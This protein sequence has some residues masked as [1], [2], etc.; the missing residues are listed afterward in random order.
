MPEPTLDRWADLIEQ[1]A[2]S[3]GQTLSADVV[4]EL[5]CYVADLYAEAREDGASE[6]VAC[7]RVA[8]VLE[9]G[10]F[11]ELTRRTRRRVVTASRLDERT[12]SRASRWWADAVFD[13]RYALRG[14]RR[15]VAFTIAVV[16][17]LAVG[18][19]ATTAAFTVIDAVLLRALPYPRPADLV[20]LKKVTA[21]SGETRALAM[22]DWR[23]YATG[24]AASLTL[25]A[26]ASWPMNLTGGGEPLR[27]RS[28]IVSGD[29]FDVIGESALVGRVT[30][31]ADDAPSAPGVVVLSYGFWSHRLGRSPAAVGSQLTI[32]GRTATIV[33]VMPQE[34]SLPSNDVDLWMPMGLPPEVLA[35]RA[36]EWVS[37]I[38]RLRPGVSMAAAQTGLSAT[39][40][41]SRND[42]RAPIAATRRGAAAARYRRRRRAAP[43][44][45]R[46]RRVLF[47]LLAGCA[48]AANLLLA[49]AT[50]RRDEIALRAA[51]GA[52]PGRPCVS[53][54]SRAW[55]WRAP[56]ASP[57]SPR[58]RRSCARSSC[59]ARIDSPRVEHAQLNGGRR[60]VDRRVAC[61]RSAV[62]RRR[63]VAARAGAGVPRG[64]ARSTALAS[65]RR[66][67]ARRARSR[68][69]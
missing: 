36:S 54:S 14:M 29:F 32:N 9:R 38:G 63:G 15:N 35:D 49:R 51:L 39:A 46:R 10:A 52:E 56:A 33:G 67:P 11:D 42:S 27:L 22:A 20:V 55:C 41:C 60:R 25:A 47:V 66:I 68:S 31:A 62:R 26:Y 53:C 24:N 18:I 13:V 65:P 4:D 69:R 61:H 58:P 1:R 57:A 12:P 34:F 43:V 7:D 44:V 37:V 64:S 5:A 19:G 50:T 8:G 16:S 3:H 21:A 2:A 30:T 28:I 6:A 40:R 48:N 23:D 17:I 59:S 45:A